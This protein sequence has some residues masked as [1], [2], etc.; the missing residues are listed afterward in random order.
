MYPQPPPPG[1]PEQPRL[2]FPCIGVTP[3]ISL[4]TPDPEEI[5]E[6]PYIRRS[7]FPHSFTNQSFIARTCVRNVNL[8]LEGNIRE[9][10]EFGN[11]MIIVG[12][13]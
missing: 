3:N 5:V 10:L 7:T 6:N 8:G 12:L 2:I 1:E 13:Y 9:D 4:L 11:T